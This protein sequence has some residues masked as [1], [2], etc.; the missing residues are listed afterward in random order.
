MSPS[1]L[2]RK[3]STVVGALYSEHLVAIVDHSRTMGNEDNGLVV[4]RQDVLQ[5]LALGFWVKGTRS[6]IEEHDATIAQQTAGYGNTLR[7]SF[8]QS[9]SLFAAK[10]IQPAGNSITK[11]AQLLCRASI[12]SSSV[13]SSLPN[14]RLSRIV[15]LISVLP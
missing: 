7:L 15:P 13:A 12:I 6:L 3:Y 10:S 4:R 14:R 8:T 11:S 5:Q 2:K 9:S 1:L